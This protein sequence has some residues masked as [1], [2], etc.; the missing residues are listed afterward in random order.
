[1]AFKVDAPKR[2]VFT[3]DVTISGRGSKSDPLVASRSFGTSPNQ[4]SFDTTGHQTMTGTAKPWEDLRIEPVARTAGTGAP[5]FEKWF[6][7]V[8]GTSRG[9]FLY[10]F[11]NETVAGN[12][13]EVFFSMQMPHAWDGGATHMHVHF[14]PAAT[15]NSTSVL[16]GL[17]YTWKGVGEIYGDT[18]IVYSSTTL[19]P[20]DVNITANKHY[21]AAFSSLVPDST[22]NTISSILIGRLFRNSSSSTDNYT[23]KLGLL[24]VD[25]HYQLN[26][27]GSTDEYI[28]G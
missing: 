9:V 21:I 12:E 28:K 22:N 18:T 27:L 4:T 1:M 6:A 17:E 3:D 2:W 11:T 14:V 16:W 24:Y 23:N 8:P 26:S 20:A 10:S 13:K 7:N 15:E 25:L 19:S 5:A